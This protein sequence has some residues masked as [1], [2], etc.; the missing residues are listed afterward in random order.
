[1]SNVDIISK[2]IEIINIR[3]FFDFFFFK[4]TTIDNNFYHQNNFF[5]SIPIFQVIKNISKINSSKL[6]KKKK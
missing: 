4:L 3:I 5:F 1:M 2:A 6:F